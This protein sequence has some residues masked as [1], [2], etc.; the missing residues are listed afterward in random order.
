MLT[1]LKYSN[2]L[3][4]FSFL[5]IYSSFTDFRFYKIWYLFLSGVLLA[6]I[7]F[8]LFGWW[9]LN[10][11]IE[12]YLVDSK[13]SL[14]IDLLSLKAILDLISIFLLKILYKIESEDEMKKKIYF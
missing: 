10:A 9:L 8:G 4:D 3:N 1:E 2:F 12:N 11:F 13:F 7:L 5:A 6:I 14:S